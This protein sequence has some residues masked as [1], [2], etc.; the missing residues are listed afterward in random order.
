MIY[1]INI[2]I[3][4]NKISNIDKN[5]KI[6]T[7]ANS[8]DCPINLAHSELTNKFKHSFHQASSTYNASIS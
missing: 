2:K 6:N 3:I 8:I 7:N 1:N 5:I 4:N